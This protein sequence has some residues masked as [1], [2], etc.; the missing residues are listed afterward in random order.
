MHKNSFNLILT[1]VLAICSVKI[2]KHNTSFGHL[3][4]QF[5]F[6]GKLDMQQTNNFGSIEV[7]EDERLLRAFIIMQKTYIKITHII[8]KKYKFPNL[9][10]PF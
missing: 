5:L 3:F 8:F 2:L 9:K 7:D 1:Y 10:E 6:E 4:W